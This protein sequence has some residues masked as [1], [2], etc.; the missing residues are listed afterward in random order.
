MM[1]SC[2]QIWIQNAR[3]QFGLG[4]NFTWHKRARFT[5][6]WDGKSCLLP[7][8]CSV[9]L[10][11]SLVVLGN[12]W[13]EG[14]L[15]SQIPSL[16]R[17]GFHSMIVSSLGFDFWGELESPTIEEP[18]ESEEIYPRPYIWEHYRAALQKWS[19]YSFSYAFVY[20]RRNIE[21][22]QVPLSQRWV[23]HTLNT[24][25]SSLLLWI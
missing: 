18:R 8:V 24:P 7:R 16:H 22:F 11:P 15:A 2:F 6:V 21:V 17:G 13:A 5:V 3:G 20:F 19:D 10:P 12:G 4:D 23:M 14:W 1:I 25:P 9:S